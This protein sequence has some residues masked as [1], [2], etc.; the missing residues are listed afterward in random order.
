MTSYAK[1]I[2]VAV[3]IFFFSL[4]CAVALLNGVDIGSTLIRG[5][6]AAVISMVLATLFGYVIFAR[7]PPPID[8]P[9]VPTQTAWETEQ[10][11]GLKP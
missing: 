2:P 5:G 4:A 6:V 3:G 11:N 7:K 8:P 10:K 9:P 1:K